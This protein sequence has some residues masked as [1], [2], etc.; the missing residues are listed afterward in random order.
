MQIVETKSEY[1]RPRPRLETFVRK[2][3]PFQD[4]Y[5]LGLGLG[6]AKLFTICF[7]VIPSFWIYSHYI[8]KLKKNLTAFCI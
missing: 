1:T 8:K 2:Q 4:Y 7:L 6:L 5:R 3:D